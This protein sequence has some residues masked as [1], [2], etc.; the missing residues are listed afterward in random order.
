MPSH[1]MSHSFKRGEMV[2]KEDKNGIVVL[3]RRD[4]RDVRI[5]STKHAPIL[6]PGKQST[7]SSRLSKLKPLAVLE[8]NIGKSGI[9]KSDQMTSYAT[10]IR[11]SIKWYRKLAM[12]LLLGTTIVNAHIVYQEAT[13]TKVDIRS[14][15][16]MLVEEWLET[17]KSAKDAN[18][19]KK[20]GKCTFRRYEKIRM[21]NLCE[22]CVF[23]ATGINAR[24]QNVI[25]KF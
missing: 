17:Q 23:R 9:D 13:K 24:M 4:V 21:E 6:V 15:R 7:V 25:I 19:S 16:E 10:N 3:K 18:N 5:L 12:Y 14:F 20:L 11:K 2:A 8:Y 1:V 22:E